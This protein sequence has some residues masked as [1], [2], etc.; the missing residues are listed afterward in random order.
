M[1]TLLSTIDDSFDVYMNATPL[2]SH[3]EDPSPVPAAVFTRPSQ[4][5]FD[6]VYQN[7]D[8]RFL[9]DAARAGTRCIAGREMLVAQGTVQFR[10]FTGVTPDL[11][12]F[13]ANFDRGRALRA[14]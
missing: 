14:G 7:A 11:D 6:M 5:A 2:G 8:T 12:E 13:Q 3:R 10:H 9:A 1:S 4:I